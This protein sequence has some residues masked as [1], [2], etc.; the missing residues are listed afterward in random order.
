MAMAARHAIMFT[1]MMWLEAMVTSATVPDINR[2]II[3]VGSGKE[4]SVTDVIRQVVEITDANPEIV[5]NQTHDSGPSR[6]CADLGIARKK[7]S[8]TPKVSLKEGL[9]RTIEGFTQSNKNSFL[10]FI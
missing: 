4:T 3:N 9:K 10:A 1:S 7:L 2:L 5:M 6:M 8:Y